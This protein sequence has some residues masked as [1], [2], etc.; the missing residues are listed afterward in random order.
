[1]SSNIYTNLNKKNII[2]IIH[3]FSTLE[4]WT[5]LIGVRSLDYKRL[6][7]FCRTTGMY[8]LN[9][10]KLWYCNDSWALVKCWWYCLGGRMTWLRGT[11]KNTLPGSVGNS[12]QNKKNFTRPHKKCHLVTRM[13]IS[14]HD[15]YS[16]SAFL[17]ASLNGKGSLRISGIESYI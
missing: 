16:T 9:F 4:L 3:N 6:I 1:M 14:L 10:V 2:I 15:S 7:W 8:V 11:V 12:K 5:L 13:W 17:K